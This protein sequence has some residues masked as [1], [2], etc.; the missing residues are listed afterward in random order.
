MRAKEFITEQKLEDV[1][2]YLD[3]AALALPNAFMIKD[4][5]NQDFYDLYRFGV[6]IADVRGTSGKDGVFND[7]KPRFKSESQW[8]EHQIVVSSDPDIEKVIDAALKK[9]KKGGKIHVATKSSE[10]MLDT[11]KKSPLN[12]FKGY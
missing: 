11:D 2:D 1:H 8:G 9:V 12:A 3:M 5:K 6:A 7:F 10:E 4:L